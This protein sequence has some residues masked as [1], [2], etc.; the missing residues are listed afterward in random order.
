MNSEPF[1][2]LFDQVWVLSLPASAGRRQHIAQHLP[3]IGLVD[4]HFF[5]ATPADDP[6][7]AQAQA[8]GEVAT[9][10]PCFRCGAV[11]CGNPDC[12]N[13]LIPSQVAC[14][15]SYRRLWRAIAAGEASRVLVVEDDVWFHP[16]TRRVLS[17]AACEAAAGRLPFAAGKTC[18]LRLGWAHCEEHGGTAPFALTTAIRMANPCHALTRD[19]ARAL[20][21]RDRGICHTVDVYQHQLAPKPGEAFTVLPPVASEL[22]WTNGCFAS[23]IHPKKVR[24]DY[25]RRQGDAA[26]AAAE[27]RRCAR[28]VKRK[29]YRPLLITGHPGCGTASAA[30]LCRQRGVD[31]GHEKLG[32]D[33]IG[34]WMFAV[35]A[36]DNPLAHDA[37]VRSRRA[38]AWDFLVLPGRDL[39]QAV[40]AF[41]RDARQA[42]QSYSF[43]RQHIAEILGIDL[44]SFTT[45]LERA[46]RSILCW[47][48]II[49][50]QKPNFLF[51]IEDN[52]EQ[53]LSFLLQ[54]NLA[55]P[56]YSTPTLDTSPG[57]TDRMQ[58][59]TRHSTPGIT[60]A[61]WQELSSDTLRLATWYCDLFGYNHPWADDT[62]ACQA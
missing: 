5:K 19:Y 59:H 57:D 10:P 48:L 16:H 2:S 22:S 33:G 53:L 56:A 58:S 20:L 32:K 29:Y 41:R 1:R 35:D 43:R 21:A 60:A 23:T 13:F 30:A 39:G 40:D 25:L 51:R 24:E 62:T 38:L 54:N 11:E 18:L 50:R 15:L 36:L 8:N 28:H 17:W 42:A 49:Y 61:D 27:G 45:P 9:F 37:V 55:N 4:F 47:T 26:S 14:F 12:N 34:A 6:A 44:D 52:H 46:V 7:V 31:V 3:A